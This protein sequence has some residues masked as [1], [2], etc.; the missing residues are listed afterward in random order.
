M[1]VK[2]CHEQV[3][4]S[5]KKQAYFYQYFFP[6]KFYTSDE[7]DAP[8]L[9]EFEGHEEPIVLTLPNNVKVKDLKWISVW[10]R[11]WSISYGD[12]IWADNEIL[13]TV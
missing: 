6:G 7:H 2:I 8:V 13:Q 4:I 11:T 3:Q 10:D 5:S 1:F 9:K 12:M